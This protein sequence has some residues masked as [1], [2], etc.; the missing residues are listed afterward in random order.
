MDTL[1]AL[2]QRVISNADSPQRLASSL[3]QIVARL[4]IS[5]ASIR[6]ISDT[7]RHIHR[8]ELI[9]IYWDE[10]SNTFITSEGYDIHSEAELWV[11][12]TCSVE[13]K[14]VS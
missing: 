9:L 12:L 8:T 13:K 3:S 10:P 2:V 6:V 4:T 1:R 5:T 14:G 11:I 7:I